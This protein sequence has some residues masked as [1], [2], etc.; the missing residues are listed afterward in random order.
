MTCHAAYQC[1]T[2]DQVISPVFNVRSWFFVR[3][4]EAIRWCAVKELNLPNLAYQT[5]PLNH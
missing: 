3:A 4:R 5:W 2:L 1:P